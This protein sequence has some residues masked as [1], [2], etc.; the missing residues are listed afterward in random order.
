MGYEVLDETLLS[1]ARQRPNAFDD[2]LRYLATEDQENWGVYVILKKFDKVGQK[3]KAASQCASLKTRYG[4]D[5]S[6]VGFT[7]KTLGDETGTK[8]LLV[9]RYA[10]DKIVE[11]AYQQFLVEKEQKKA[12]AK[13]A[14]ADKAEKAKVEADKIAEKVRR[15]QAKEAKEEVNA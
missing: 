6:V 1:K 3:G 2:D 15:A 13:V 14:A 4:S 7:F 8:D 10:P 9:V 11:G 5:E 12:A